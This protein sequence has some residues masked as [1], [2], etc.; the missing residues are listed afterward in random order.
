[1]YVCLRRSWPMG[2]SQNNF[3]YDYYPLSNTH[4]TLRLFFQIWT[5]FTLILVIN[6][7]N[8]VEAFEDEIEECPTGLCDIG[9]CVEQFTGKLACA[10]SITFGL[11]SAVVIHETGSSDDSAKQRLSSITK[12]VLKRQQAN[13]ANLIQRALYSVIVSL[14]AIY[15]V[16]WSIFGLWCFVYSIS[17]PDGSS[18]PL[19]YTGQTWL[20]ITIRASYSFFGVGEQS[21]S[22]ESRH[23]H[24]AQQDSDEE[25][26]PL[27]HN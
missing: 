2:K 20:G 11:L 6:N 17:S 3:S 15:V 27:Q 13:N 22:N 12:P 16:S 7:N 5:I 21:S 8:C 25:T 19:F 4:N 14:P 9:I 23:S 10:H 26:G 18:G 24:R 1:M